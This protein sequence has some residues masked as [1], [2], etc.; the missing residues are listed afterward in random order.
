VALGLLPRLDGALM[1]ATKED[2]MKALT[3]WTGVTALRKEM[4][5][6]FDRFW[7]TDWPAWPAL[8]DWMPKVDVADTK[9]AFMVT[10][11]I[12]GIDPKD[13]TLTLDG[14]ALTIKGEKKH[15]KEE[16]EGTY[17]RMERAYGAFARTMPLPAPVEAGK[18]TATFKNGIL[19][20]K[21][22]KGAA[23]KGTLIPI[24]AE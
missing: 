15:E 7:E 14:D 17:F 19:T 16:K 21:L 20:V 8:G 11:E 2:A 23:A 10:A 1:R 22:P 18:V 12:P 3:P 6:L 24:K 13:I 9:D 5:R 4:D